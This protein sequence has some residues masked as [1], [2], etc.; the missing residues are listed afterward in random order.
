MKNMSEKCVKT[1]VP[2]EL[3]RISFIFDWNTHYKN[4]TLH[5]AENIAHFWKKHQWADSW[6]PSIF[7]LSKDKK[8][9][10]LLKI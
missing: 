5:F 2:W 8:D 4:P 6:L 3:S 10:P 1:P 7:A 9:M